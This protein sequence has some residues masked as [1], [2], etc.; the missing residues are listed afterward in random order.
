MQVFIRIYMYIY[1]Y[2]NTQKINLKNVYKNKINLSKNFI[3]KL[4]Y[5]YRKP[6]N[7]FLRKNPF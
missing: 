2:H 1:N 3:L 6:F 4:I 7:K 5:I